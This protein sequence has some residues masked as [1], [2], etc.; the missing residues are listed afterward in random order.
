[1]FK[2]KG[3]S[4]RGVLTRLNVTFLRLNLYI[5]PLKL[6]FH[7]FKSNRH[8]AKSPL[9]VVCLTG[10]GERFGPGSPGA[11]CSLTCT[12]AATEKSE[13]PEPL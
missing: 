8:H 1:M 5:L 12:G 9:S 13:P 11:K 7:L 2:T 3:R 10:T 6:K 4:V